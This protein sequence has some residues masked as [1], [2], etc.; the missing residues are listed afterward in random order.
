MDFNASK[1]FVLRITHTRS[2]IQFSYSLNNTQLQET[3]NHDYLGVNL[4]NDLSWNSHIGNITAKANRSLGFIRRN[5]FSCSMHTKEMAYKMLVR[6]ILEYGSSVWDPH[7][8]KL[9]KQVEAVQNRAAR[10]VS[11]INYKKCSISKVKKDLHWDDLATR[12]KVAR[13]T[14]FHQAIGGHLAI[15]ARNILRPV[16]RSTR[17]TSPTTNN[18]TPIQA[19]KDCYKQSFLPRTVID[20]NQLPKSITTIVDKQQFKTAINQHFRIQDQEEIKS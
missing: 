9:I 17:L 4:S 2:P 16:Q 3:T 15:P 10:F 14:N 8:Q 11:G 13:L 6:P 19:S 5:L 1:C 18:F 12:R 20:W 7:T